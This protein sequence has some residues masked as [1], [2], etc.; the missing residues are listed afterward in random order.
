MLFCNSATESATRRDTPGV[1]GSFPVL[2]GMAP[3]D[4]AMTVLSCWEQAV[5]WSWGRWRE[6]ELRVVRHAAGFVAVVGQCLASDDRVARDAGRVLESG[7]WEPLTRWPG[8]YLTI[9]VRKNE[10]TVFADLA[11]QY[12]LYY[13][14]ASG[15]TVF[16]SHAAITAVAA[17]VTV[18]PDPLALAAQLFC[19]ATSVLVGTRSVVEG[20]CRLGGGQ[21]LSLARNGTCRTWTYETLAPEDGTSVKEGADTLRSTLDC[22]V[23]DRV[24]GG[25]HV[26][27]DFSGGYD[28]TTVAFLAA[29]HRVEPMRVFTYHHPGAPAGDL[30]Y[31]ERYALLDRGLRLEVVLGDSDTLTYRALTVRVTDTPDPG[32]ASW[33]R[34][35]LRLGRVADSGNGIHLG[36]EGADALLAAPPAYLADLARH[37]MVR[38]LGS[39]ARALAR[40]RQESPATVVAMAVRLARTSIRSA[41]NQLADQ[42][43]HPADR[44]TRW[45]D[46]ISWWPPPGTEMAW[47]TRSMRRQLTELARAAASQVDPMEEFGIGDF[48]AL[49]ELRSSAAVQRQLSE[50][51]R[52]FS[53]WPHAPFLDNDVIRA[54][55]AVPAYR[56][57]DTAVVKPLLRRAMAGLVP[58]Q[59]FERH[60]KG[61]YSA[62]DYRGARAEASALT[63]RLMRS[64]LADLG[65]I[66]PRAVIAS[67]DQ[68]GAGARIP[69]PSLNRVL[70]VDLWLEGLANVPPPR[71][72]VCPCG[73]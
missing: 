73:H 25:R 43:E 37:R 22:A 68:L 5:L 24:R 63:A 71:E 21:A 45:L 16:G 6:G 34:T 29:R 53:V 18:R 11:G 26:T 36:G 49:E 55:T 1:V 56:R 2:A 61:N 40:Q 51:A 12:P 35:R 41:I 15:R 46:A 69:I 57:A 7:H 54:C 66:E 3:P 9:M 59:I 67:L 72:E 48:V 47:L 33:S 38:R 20:V 4:S 65:V 52:D 27:A 58:D 19:P 10:V 13:V 64:S 17:S 8:S 31:A 28:S 23:R 32:A 70:S 30:E 50:A 62:E 60:T 39:D 44:G 42:I 14:S